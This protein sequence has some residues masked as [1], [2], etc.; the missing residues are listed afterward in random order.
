MSAQPRR[1][2]PPAWTLRSLAV[3]WA[4]VFLLA[5]L[6]SAPAGRA[7]AD[8]PASAAAKPALSKNAPAKKAAKKGGPPAR[9][10]LAAPDIYERLLQSTCLIVG[11]HAPTQSVVQIGTGWLYDAPKRLVVTNEHV[12]TSMDSAKPG[13]DEV[14][15]YF[16]MI[17]DGEVVSEPGEYFKEPNP[18]LGTVIHRDPRSDLALVRLD[19]VPEGMTSLPLA[20]QSPKPGERVHT[21]G[22]LPDGSEGMWIYAGGEVRRVYR[23]STGNL[24]LAQVVESQLP[25][26]PGNSGGP[27]VNDFAEIVAVHEGGHKTARLVVMHIDLSELRTFLDETVPL[28]DPKTAEAYN[29]RGNLRLHAGRYDQAIRDYTEAIKLDASLTVALVNRGWAFVW[30]EDYRTARRDF[31]AAVQ[32]E[33]ENATAYEGRGLCSRELGQLDEAIDD[34]T[35]AIRRAPDDADLYQRRANAFKLKERPE[36][37]LADRNRAVELDGRQTPTYL[38]DRAQT[39]QRMG[40]NAEAIPD[41]EAAVT[42]E[43]GNWHWFYEW[44]ICLEKLERTEQAVAV[45]SLGL[46]RNANEA[47][48]HYMRAYCLRQLKRY[49]ESV[50]GFQDAIRLNPNKAHY[51]R[52]LAYSLQDLGEYQ[53]AIAAYTKAIE[54]DPAHASAY[55]GRSECYAAIGDQASADADSAKATELREQASKEE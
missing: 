39:L 30:K 22:A 19:R 52:H 51:H 38:V 53:L 14:R 49:A 23:R 3:V 31:D 32:Q 33:P 17:R 43:P 40:R 16:P 6:M 4:T 42:L 50:A 47:G 12:V 55:I 10:K 46:Q 5:S 45:F 9:R 35:E 1:A 13:F 2:T 41:L 54:L 34:F 21:V 27:V 29:E 24:R 20:K 37:E 28:A 48:L 25:T 18:I 8:E 26:N 36:E 44:G 7:A 15:V 11:Y